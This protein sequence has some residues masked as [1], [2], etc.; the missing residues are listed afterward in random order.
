M[1]VADEIRQTAK[2]ML[3]FEHKELFHFNQE[4]FNLSMLMHT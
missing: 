3:N 4:K 2:I 1:A